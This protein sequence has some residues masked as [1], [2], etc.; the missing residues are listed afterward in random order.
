MSLSGILAFFGCGKNTT[1]DDLQYGNFTIKRKVKRSSHYNVNTANR[2]KTAHT[3]YHIFYKGEAVVMPPALNQSSGAPGIWKV[4]NIP[5]APKPTLMVASQSVYLLAEEN[6]QPLITPVQVQTSDFATLQW[7]DSQDGLPGEK[8]TIFASDDSEWDGLLQGGE[9]IFVNSRAVLNIPDLTV[10]SFPEITADNNGF[11]SSYVAGFSPDKDKIVFMARNNYK[12]TYA[13]IVHNFKTHE[14]YNVHFDRNETRLNEP[15]EVQPAWMDKYF[16]WEALEDGSY[17]LQKRML[18]PLPNWE[19]NFGRSGS[20]A[21]DPVMPD[22]FDV[23]IEFLKGHLKLK[24]G[25][26]FKKS[27]YSDEW[28]L[29]KD[30]YRIDISLLFGKHDNYHTVYCSKYFGEDESGEINAIIESIGDAFNEELR[31]GNHQDLFTGYD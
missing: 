9:N 3:D 4:F 6:G 20:Y 17:E 24:E 30:G 23:F 18:D 27:S 26:S 10:Y 12:K 19:G 13:L 1:L 15:F 5:D 11:Y 2:S 22:M 8:E 31:K 28:N 29:V 14:I 21:I 16:K 25:D 7:L